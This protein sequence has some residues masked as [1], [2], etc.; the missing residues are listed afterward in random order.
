[1]NLLSTFSAK[2]DS[3]PQSINPNPLHHQ[4]QVQM[5]TSHAKQRAEPDQSFYL[6]RSS[7]RSRE[8]GSL[9]NFGKRNYLLSKMPNLKFSH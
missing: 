4:S 2:A 3:E 1:M 8:V 9:Q 6:H 5:L 7:R